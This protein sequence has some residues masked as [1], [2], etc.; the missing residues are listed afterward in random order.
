MA[1]SI[2]DMSEDLVA[3][4]VFSSLVL[5]VCD[6]LKPYSGGVQK[7]VLGLLKESLDQMLADEPKAV[8]E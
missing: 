4:A 1:H 6:R 3:S 5:D 8:N 2:S 7:K